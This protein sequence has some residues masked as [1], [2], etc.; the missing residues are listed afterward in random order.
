MICEKCGK[1]HNGSYSSGRFC[2]SACTR[3]YATTNVNR[4]KINEKISNYLNMYM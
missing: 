3:S 2:S 1:E 4:N